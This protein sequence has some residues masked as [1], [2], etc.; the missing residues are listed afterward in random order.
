MDDA[1]KHRPPG[2][3]SFI[4]KQAKA[5]EQAELDAARYGVAYIK[6]MPNGEWECIDPSRI[7]IDARAGY[8]GGESENLQ[9]L[10]SDTASRTHS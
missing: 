4:A 8:P 1:L 9:D 2:R 10:P 3:M 5:R 6:V 7:S